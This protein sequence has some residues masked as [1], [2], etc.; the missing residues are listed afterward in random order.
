MDNV[1]FGVIV[2]DAIDIG[3]GVVGRRVIQRVD[4][5]GS[6]CLWRVVT[7]VS[8]G[9]MDGIE[10]VGT[11]VESIVDSQVMVISGKKWAGNGILEK[12][13]NQEK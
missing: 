5:C 2:V 6:W 7:V 12:K 9:R 1:R 13:K 3:V 11:A 10:V 4:T 8:G